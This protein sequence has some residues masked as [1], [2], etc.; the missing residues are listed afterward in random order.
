MKR[1]LEVDLMRLLHGELPAASARELR[2]RM[3]HEPELAAAYRRLAGAWEGL[4][5]PPAAPVPLG[6]SGRVMAQVRAASRPGAEA[7]LRWADAPRWVRATAAAALLVGV[8][9]GAGLG[10]RGESEEGRAVAGNPALTESYWAMVDE[11]A[12]TPALPST[13]R[14]EARR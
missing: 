6:W 10:V 7:S 12:N 13:P 8:A 9:L 14:G 2:Q 3:E 11:S 4:E 1:D 5:L